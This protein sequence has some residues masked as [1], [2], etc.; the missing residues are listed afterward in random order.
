MGDADYLGAGDVTT[1]PPSGPVG[2]FYPFDFALTRNTPTFASA[3]S[4]NFTYIGQPFTY[5]TLPVATVTARNAAGG[6]TQ[7]YVGNFMKIASTSVTPALGRCPA[8]S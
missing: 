5:A 8:H 1:S 2:R 4:S 7:N 3:C 6:T